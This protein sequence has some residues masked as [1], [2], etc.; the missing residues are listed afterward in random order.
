MALAAEKNGDLAAV[1][2]GRDGIP[3]ISWQRQGAPWHLF[4]RIAAYDNRFPDGFT[5]P[6]GAPMA[7]AAEKNGD[8]AAVVVG[9]DGVPYISW[10]RQGAPW[11][12]F[13]R[14]AAFDNRFPDGF[15]VPPGAPMA[16]AAQKNGDLAVVVVGGDRIPYI[17]WQQQGAPWHLYRPPIPA[18]CR[19]HRWRSDIRGLRFG[20]RRIRLR[21]AP[22][23]R[24]Q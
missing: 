15:T 13:E 2:V 20:L 18:A 19:F 6:P 23:E 22:C 12:L 9:R 5:V 11:H 21:P 10:Q 16:L 7:L 14:I 8:L 1:V 17:S 4:E 3:Y 24:P